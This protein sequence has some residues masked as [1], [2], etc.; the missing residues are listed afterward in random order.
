M[1]LSLFRALIIAFLLLPACATPP[2]SSIP[3]DAYT[4]PASG[5]VF[6]EHFDS[7]DRESLNKDDSDKTPVMAH[8]TATDPAHITAD[9]RLLH[10]SA[11]TPDQLL[12]QSVHSMETYPNFTQSDYHGQRSFG[13]ETA[14]CTQCTFDRPAS[15]GPVTF[16][17]LIIPRGNYLLCLTFLLPAT[18]EAQSQSLIDTFIQEIV[19]KSAKHKVLMIP[20]ITPSSEPSRDPDDN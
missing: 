18:Q 4:D 10:A 9:I 13:A 16:K 17:I 7:L 5:V 3:D 2:K 11:I 8:Y 14:F 20:T 6:P 19:T 15:G 1:N 12:G